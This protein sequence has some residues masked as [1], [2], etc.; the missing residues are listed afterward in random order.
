[1]TTKSFHLSDILSISTGI[2]VSNDYM[3][4]VYNILG[5][6]TEDTLWTHQLPLAADAMRPELLQQLPWLA[7]VEKPTVKLSGEA[8]CVA[9]VASVADVYGEWHE[10]ESAPLAWGTHDAV[11]DFKNEYPDKPIVTVHMDDAS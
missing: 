9:W 2:L 1:M 4:G 7:K 5:H 6:M 10:V 8:E 3:D 11:Q